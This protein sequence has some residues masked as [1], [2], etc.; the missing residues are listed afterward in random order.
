MTE[1][2]TFSTG[3]GQSASPALMGTI[4]IPCS[5]AVKISNLSFDRAEMSTGL[6][7]IIDPESI[8]SD[9]ISTQLSGTVDSTQVT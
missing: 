5:L 2:Q 3:Q 1:S 7:S 8:G 6:A 4:V 9:I